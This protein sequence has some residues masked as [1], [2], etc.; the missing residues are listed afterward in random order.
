MNMSAAKAQKKAAKQGYPAFLIRE[1]KGMISIPA[2]SD[3]TKVD[4]TYP[5]IEDFAYAKIS[6]DNQGKKLVYRV[7]EPELEADDRGMLR[8]IEESLMELIDVKMSVLRNREE[9]VQYLQS[10]I[11]KVL[12]DMNIVLPAE[13]YMKVAY[14]LVRNFVG[15]NEVEPFM[16]DPYIEDIGCSG[17][18]TPVY[19]IHK[20]FGSIETNL[21]Y[22]DIDNLSNFV[23]KI[24]E[25][26]GR[27]ISYA[28]P[29]LD[30]RLP[31][32][33]RVQASYA[34]DVTTKGPTFTIRKF[35]KNPF[36]PVDMIS[37]RTASLDMM[38]YL[39][40]LIEHSVSVLICGGVST[41]KT[42]FL[43]SLSMFIPRERK[44]ISIEDTREINLPHDNWI[45]AVSREG[46]GIPESTGKRYG[47]VDLF[48][49]LK[50][51][52]R[53]NPDYV[54]V[55][56]VRGKEAY[57]MFQGMASGHSSIGTLHAGSLEDVIKRLE[58]PPIDLSPSLIESLDAIIVMTNAKE[59]GKSAR[60]VKEISEIQ[61][62]DASTGISH[63]KRVFSWIPSE[64]VFKEEVMESFVLQKISFEE[65]ATM[66]RTIAELNDRKAVL[67]WMLR[68]NIMHYEHVCDVINLYYK[69]KSRVM[70]WVKGN[71]SPF[72]KKDD[73]S[74]P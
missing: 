67:S 60:R 54:I 74:Q 10:K 25:R 73:A 53:Q 27:Y 37:M 30:G 17:V 59:K 39:W 26:C 62:V 40:L 49:L 70:G 9:S 15:L 66:Q 31:D 46:F 16:F 51:S 58:T 64:D 35:R 12:S 1:P 48:D 7:V 28:T 8:K 2:F 38:A 56:E 41:G 52:F 18:G 33:S 44:V 13:K 47:E 57:V 29:L 72:S 4:I 32:G 14:Y 43:N 23:I 19:I 24:S 22:T 20:K 55:G 63:S 3:I 21:T 69:E 34:K 50:E 65:G 71:Q 45:P 61:S 68:Q 36:S 11:Q 6:W 42:S 5:L